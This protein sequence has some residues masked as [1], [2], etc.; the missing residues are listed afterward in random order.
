[1]TTKKTK[2]TKKLLDQ[3]ARIGEPDYEGDFIRNLKDRIPNHPPTT[4]CPDQ[5]CMVCGVRDCPEGEP[6]HYHHDGC[7]RCS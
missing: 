3:I 5:E 1:M 6:L 7:P 2:E 4:K